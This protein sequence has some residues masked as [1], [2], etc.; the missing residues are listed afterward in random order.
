MGNIFNFSGGPFDSDGH[1]FTYIY[2]DGYKEE[3]QPKLDN[4]VTDTDK[5]MLH[6]LGVKWEDSDGE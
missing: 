1:T 3:W 6:G 4:T 2:S 5:I